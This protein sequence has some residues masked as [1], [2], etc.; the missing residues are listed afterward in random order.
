VTETITSGFVEAYSLC[1]RKAFLLM[2]G[3]TTNPGTHG[4]ELVIRGQAD[5]NCQSYRARLEEAHE[6]VPFGGPIWPWARM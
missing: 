4:Y 2:T 5:A 1:P 6:V 3:A